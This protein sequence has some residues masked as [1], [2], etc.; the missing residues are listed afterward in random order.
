VK[1]NGYIVRQA[2]NDLE[3][4]N[5]ELTRVL[6][7][8]LTCESVQTRS[9]LVAQGALSVSK[10]SSAVRTLRSVLIEGEHE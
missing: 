9:V 2:L 8:L 1:S 10:R 6:E 5:M 4:S 7:K 3:R